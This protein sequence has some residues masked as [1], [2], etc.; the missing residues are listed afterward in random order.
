MTMT[1]RVSETGSVEI[2][3]AI[4]EARGLSA[5]TE[6]E[7]IAPDGEIVLRGPSTSDL[8][9]SERRRISLEE[10]FERVPKYD[11]PA[12]SDEMIE[13]ALVEEARRRWN[14]QGR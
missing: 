7:V 6:L 14:E 2:P 11:G 10:F 12:I 1:I 8:T 4:R 13:A 9:E 3:Q 5:G